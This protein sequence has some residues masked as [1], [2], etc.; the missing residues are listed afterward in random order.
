[1]VDLE[2]LIEQTKNINLLYIEDNQETREATL[3][4]FKIFFDNIITAVDGEDG[5]EK[6]KNN[7]IGLVI[8]DMSMPKINGMLMAKEMKQINANIPIIVLTAITN[9]STIDESRDIG[10]NSYINKPL[11]DVDILFE[12]LDKIIRGI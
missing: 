10:I 8:T 5:L 2:S 12:E 11:E 1:M 4:L 6:F 3:M 7:D 9:S